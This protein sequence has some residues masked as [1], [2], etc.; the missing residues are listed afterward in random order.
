MEWP[1]L[2][3]EDNQL[4]LLQGPVE[5]T[6]SPDSTANDEVWMSHQSRKRLPPHQGIVQRRRR[7]RQCL[8][9]KFFEYTDGNEAQ[10]YILIDIHGQYFILNTDSSVR[11]TYKDYQVSSKKRRGRRETLFRKSVEYSDKC[12]ADV[13]VIIYVNNRYITL[14]TNEIRHHRWSKLYDS[15]IQ[16]KCFY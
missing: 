14:Y 10:V 2:T 8:F 3:L 5:L 9:R 15:W 13:Y 4:N 16:L 12:S 11:K 7:R 6:S 1:Q